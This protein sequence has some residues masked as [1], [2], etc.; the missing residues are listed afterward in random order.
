M[1]DRT[2][3]EGSKSK[4][5]LL[6]TSPLLKLGPTCK[7]LSKNLTNTDFKEKQFLEIAKS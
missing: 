6:L 7:N 5:G 2:C 1:R 4:L 3:L